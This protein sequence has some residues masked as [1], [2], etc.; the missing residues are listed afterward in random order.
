VADLGEELE[1]PG[2]P[3]FGS[4]KEEIAEGRKAG[5]ASKKRKQKQKTQRLYLAE[6]LDPPLA[7]AY[8]YYAI[9]YTIF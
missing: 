8:M 5:R 9:F 7:S 6:G 3:Y 2:N 4:K 1:G